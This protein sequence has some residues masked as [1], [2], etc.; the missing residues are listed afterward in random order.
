[1]C[2]G[3]FPPQR[4]QQSEACDL[5]RLWRCAQRMRFQRSSSESDSTSVTRAPLWSLSTEKKIW[6][7]STSSPSPRCRILCT[8]ASP[9]NSVLDWRHIVKRRLH[10]S[11][12][13]SLVSIMERLNGSLLVAACSSASSPAGGLFGVRS[14]SPLLT[15]ASWGAAVAEVVRPLQR[16]HV[17]RSCEELPW[18]RREFELGLVGPSET[19]HGKARSFWKSV[20][21]TPCLSSCNS[22]FPAPAPFRRCT[23]NNW[24]R[25]V[26]HTAPLIMSVASSRLQFMS[27]VSWTPSRSSSMSTTPKRRPPR[28]GR[29]APNQQETSN[30]VLDDSWTDYP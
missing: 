14:S 19:T 2:R 3:K 18:R 16:R 27:T 24:H 11:L 30:R 29:P 28:C 23:K 26:L 21:P 9:M 8:T 7:P 20:A 12:H 25:T 6:L 4:P 5:F 15:R 13:G 10:D 1:M 17:V 22:R